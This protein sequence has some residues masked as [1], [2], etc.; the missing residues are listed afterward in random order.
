MKHAVGA[1]APAVFRVWV[2]L[3]GKVFITMFDLAI[4]DARATTGDD[5]C[6]VCVYEH[7]SSK[8]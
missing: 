2:S 1:A 5:T 3:R 7:W 6:E 8:G 4:G